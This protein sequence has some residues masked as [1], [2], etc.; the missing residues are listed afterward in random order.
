V[1][2]LRDT[3]RPLLLAPLAGAAVV[4]C[5]ELPRQGI[6]AIFAGIVA[7]PFCYA[8]EVVLVVPILLLWTSSR[9]PNLLVGA[10]WG[11]LVAWCAAAIVT[12]EFHEMVRPVVVAGFGSSG[13][14]S[15]VSYV[16]LV[17]RRSK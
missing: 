2:R 3:V 14:A 16:L 7:A 10:I 15:G 4:T 5:W 12:Q 6:E 8:A 11:A 1:I 13:I 9:S 17:R